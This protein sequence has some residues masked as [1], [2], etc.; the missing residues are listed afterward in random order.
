MKYEIDEK[1][2]LT[3]NWASVGGFEKCIE[4]DE[5]KEVDLN[6]R[7]NGITLVLDTNPKVIERELKTLREKREIECFSV[8]NRGQLWYNRLTEEQKVELDSWYNAWLDVTETMII[9]EKPSWLEG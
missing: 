8:I 4:I 9:P 6:L 7:W 5:L 1:G 3:G 2:F